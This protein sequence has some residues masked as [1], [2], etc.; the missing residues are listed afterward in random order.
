L[1]GFGGSQRVRRAPQGSELGRARAR[2]Y[3]PGIEKERLRSDQ[4]KTKAGSEAIPQHRR[5]LRG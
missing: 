3:A 4:V 2:A 1:E 5:S